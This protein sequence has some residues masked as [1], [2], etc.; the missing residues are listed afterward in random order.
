MRADSFLQFLFLLLRRRSNSGETPLAGQ[1]ADKV[2]RRSG[3]L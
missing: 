1:A 2:P 3:P